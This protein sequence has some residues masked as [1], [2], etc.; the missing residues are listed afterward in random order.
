MQQEVPQIYSPLIQSPHQDGKR[1]SEPVEDHT[2]PPKPIPNPEKQPQTPQSQNKNFTSRLYFYL[3]GTSGYSNVL[4]VLVTLPNYSNYFKGFPYESLIFFT[5]NSGQFTY[6]ALLYLLRNSS[7][8]KQIDVLLCG[9]LACLLGQSLLGMLFPRNLS[10]FLGTLLLQHLSMMGGYIIQGNAGTETKAFG[11]ETVPFLYSSYCFSTVLLS[12]VGLGLNALDVSDREYNLAMVVIV[13]V[14]IGFSLLLHQKVV[15]TDGYQM[16]I[17]K[18]TRKEGNGMGAGGFTGKDVWEAAWRIKYKMVGIFAVFVANTAVFPVLVSDMNPDYIE[19][20]A[21]NNILNV[22]SNSLFVI[23]SMLTCWSEKDDKGNKK[24]IDETTK[25]I[26]IQEKNKRGMTD[27]QEVEVD[28]NLIKKDRM[29]PKFIEEGD[30]N[31][32]QPPK[33]DQLNYVRCDPSNKGPESQA[34]SLQPHKTSPPLKKTKPRINDIS[35]LAP[36]IVAII[37]LSLLYTSTIIYAYYNRPESS[38][39]YTT[40]VLVSTSID[41]LMLGYSMNF[42]ISA[43][44]HHRQTHILYIYIISSSMNQGY[45]VGSFCTLFLYKY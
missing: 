38:A 25:E 13:A 42:I 7:L 9:I 24:N 20:P 16:I 45:L 29:V 44:I 36:H 28:K 2:C 4:F 15:K 6:P 19:R 10:S 26:G 39:L 40:V 23:G 31:E 21:W 41:N 30:K 34:P 22:I 12:A 14:Y 1:D 8:P 5:S 11:P 32:T 27:G 17:D 37:L 33:V 18:N 35:S 3:V 43:V